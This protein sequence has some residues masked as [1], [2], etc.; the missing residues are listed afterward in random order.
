LNPTAPSASAVALAQL[1]EPI[2]GDLKEVEKEFTRQL[3]SQ[4]SVIPQI[5][6][7]IKDGGGKRIRPAVLLMSARMAGYSSPSA[8]SA[9]SRSESSDCDRAV[10]YASVLEFIHTATLVHDDIIDEAELR[11]GRDAVHTKWGN[12]LTVLFGDFLYLKSM[13]MALSVDNL[14]IVRLLCDV[15]LRIVEGEIYQLTKNGVVDLSEDEHFDIVRRKTAYLFAGCARI[16]G[17]LGPTTREQQ[18][19]LWDYGLNIGMAFQIVDDL[20]DFTGDA[21]A[22]GKPV[23]GDLREG[24][25]TLPVIHLRARGDARADAL[26]RQIVAARHATAD[27]WRELTAMLTQARSIDYAQRKAAEFV[28]RAKAALYAFHSS[29]A[30]DALMYLPDYVI[31]RDR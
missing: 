4:V 24:K 20:L 19:A 29:D 27:E 5:A 16:G 11:R 14:E 23:G 6:D 3:Q 12:H 13:S 28:E 21:A 17:M 22:L 8:G 26:L 30:R 15:T 1:F 18:E 10:L 7:Y 2:R 9:T 31:S 25:M